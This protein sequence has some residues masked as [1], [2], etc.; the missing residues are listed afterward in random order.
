MQSCPLGKI[1]RPYRR[2]VSRLVCAAFVFAPLTL[3]AQDHN[4]PDSRAISP[5][6]LVTSVSSITGTAQDPLPGEL[7]D[8]DVVRIALRRTSNPKACYDNSETYSY[9][10]PCPTGAY[11][12]DR[13]WFSTG[14]ISDPLG[15]PGYWSWDSSTVYWLN[16]AAYDLQ[17]IAGDKAGNMRPYPGANSPD[18]TFDFV[19]P[20][21]DTEITIPAIENGS[22]NGGSVLSLAG[23][24]YNV[25]IQRGVQVR[26][27]RLA[28]PVAW[29]NEDSKTWVQT[30]TFTYVNVENGA[31]FWY[32]TGAEA[33]TVDGAS[34]TFTATGFNTANEAETPPTSRTIIV[35]NSAIMA[36]VT[37]LHSPAIE[38][39]NYRNAQLNALIGSGY[40]L[41][42]VDSIQVRIKRLKEPAAW[43]DQGTKTWVTEDV[44]SYTNVYGGAGSWAISID[45]AEAFTVDNASY[46]FSSVGFNG[47]NEPQAI[48]VTRTVIVDNTRPLGAVLSPNTP[49][50]N[51]MPVISGTAVDPGRGE[52]PGDSLNR[53]FVMIKEANLSRYWNGVAFAGFTQSSEFPAASTLNWS[54]ATAVNPALLDGQGYTIFVRPEDKA[55]N[56]EYDERYMPSYSVI[57]DTSSPVS[58]VILPVSLASINGTASDPAGV[59]APNLR[60]DIARVELQIYDATNGKWWHDGAG[61]FT[62]ES[63]SFNIVAGTAVWNYTNPSLAA[64]VQPGVSYTIRSRVV[65]RAGNMQFAD[66][67]SSVAYTGDITISSVAYTDITPPGTFILQPADNARLNFL[68]FVSGTAGGDISIASVTVSIRNLSNGFYWNGSAW[69][70]SR[71]WLNAS[72]TGSSWSFSAVPVFENGSLYEVAAKAK[73][74]SGNWSV[75][76]ATSTFEYSNSVPAAVADLEAVPG[77]TGGI[78]LSWTVPAADSEGGI[79]SS[80][81]F[82]VQYST[83]VGV[84]WYA[85]AAQINISI[86]DMIPGSRQYYP[87]AGLGGNTK[88]YFRLWSKKDSDYSAISNEAAVLTGIE[89]PSS[90]YF[91][92]IATTSIVASAY[93]SAPAFM[94]LHLGQSGT[95]VAIDIDAW[96]WAGWHGEA[97]TNK[98]PMPTARSA[99]AAAAANGRL[100]AQGGSESPIKSEEYDPGLD[101]WSTRT[102]LPAGRS[103]FGSAAVGGR[104]IVLGG[105]TDR[106]LNQQYDP[107]ADIWSNIPA[108]A[109]YPA[110][111]A[112]AVDEKVYSLGGAGRMCIWAVWSG[113]SCTTQYTYDN[114]EYDTSVMGWAQRQHMPTSRGNL[115]VAASSGKIYA[116]G[117]VNG[118]GSGHVVNSNEAY[119]PGSNSWSVLR[120]MSEPRHKLAAAALGGKIYAIGGDNSV[121]RVNTNEEYDPVSDIWTLRQPMPTARSGLAAAAIGG[122]IYV[123]GGADTVALNTNEE[124]D[125]GVAA[126]FDSLLP[127][128]RY[129]FKAKARDQ[130]G[131]ETAE[132]GL[133][134]ACTLAT[135]AKPPNGEPVFLFITSTSVRVNWSSGTTSGGFNGPGAIYSLEVSSSPA[136]SVPPLQYSTGS[137]SLDVDG[138]VSGRAYYF[139]VRAANA[140]GLWTDFLGLGSVT[141]LDA[142]PPISAVAFPRAGSF[143]TS[144]SCISGTSSDSGSG[145]SGVEILINYENTG[146]YFDGVGYNSS[147]VVW[148][149]VPPSNIYQSSWT[150]CSALLG[151]GGDSVRW[152]RVVSRATDLAGNVGTPSRLL[153][154]FALDLAPPQSEMDSPENLSVNSDDLELAGRA[155]DDGSGVF[156]YGSNYPEGIAKLELMIFR[157]IAPYMVVGGTMAF[158]PGSGWDD[159]GYFW[160]GS[161][162]TPSAGGEVWAPS[163]GLPSTF[164]DW[165]YTGLVCDNDAERLAHACWERDSIYAA[166]VRA[167]DDVG[168]VETAIA[169]GPRFHIGTP[170]RSFYITVSTDPI[171]AGSDIDMTVTALDGLFGNG[172]TVDYLGTINFYV[173]GV[174]GSPEVMDN[175]AVADNI[176]GLPQQYT[177]VPG[178]HGSKTFRMRLRKAGIRILRVEDSPYYGRFGNRVVR[179]NPA[180]PGYYKVSPGSDTNASTGF[181]LDP[182]KQEITAQFTDAFGNS[183]SSAGMPA[184]LELGEVHGSTGAIQYQNEDRRFWTDIGASTIMYTDSLGRIGVSTPIAYRV[185]RQPGDWARVWIGTVPVNRETYSAYDAAGQNLSGRLISDKLRSA[186]LTPCRNCAVYEDL[187][188]SGAASNE[189]FLEGQG[190]V[191]F[192]VFRDTQPV[193]YD[194]TT[195]RYGEWDMSG[196]F[197]NGSTWTPVSAGPVWLQAEMDALGNW[198]YSDLTCDTKTEHKTGT[199][200][201]R[202]EIYTAWSRAADAAGNVESVAE[203]Q[204]FYIL[205]KTQSFRITSA[206]HA[207]VGDIISLRVTA[208]IEPGGEGYNDPNYAGAFKFYL[209]GVQVGPDTINNYDISVDE[210]GLPKNYSFHYSDYG[211][212]SLE[213]R[214]RNPGENR[215]LMVQDAADPDI[216]GSATITVEVGYPSV[217]ILTP[218]GAPYLASLPQIFGTVSDNKAVAS[219]EV[220]L[221][222]QAD[223]LHWGGIEWAESQAWLGATLFKSS[224]TYTSI[225][226]LADGVQYLVAARARDASG[227]WSLA[228]STSIFQYDADPP[229]SAVNEP[230]DGAAMGYFSG[231]SGT[232]LDTG[233]GVGQ[234][235]VKIGRASDNAYWD[236][237]GS[238]WTEVETWALAT[239]SSTWTCAGPPEASLMSGATYFAVSRAVDAVGN[240]QA[241]GG[242]SSTFIYRMPP[243]SGAI[244][245]IAG[246]LLGP[247]SVHWSWAAGSMNAVDGYGIFTATGGYLATVALNA[248]GGA[249]YIQTGLAPDSPVSVQVGGYNDGGFGPLAKSASYYTLASAPGEVTVSAVHISSV[250]LAWSLNGNPPGIFAK[251][252]RT[253]I[254][255]FFST[256]G[257]SYTYTGLSSCTSYYFRVWNVNNSDIPTEAVDVGPAFTGSNAPPPPGGLSAQPLEGNRISLGWTLAPS[258]DISGYNLYFD[259]GS[260][261]LDYASP[262]AAL[263]AGQAGYTTGVLFSSAA[264]TFGL[265]SVNGCGLEEKNTG[266]TV[267][268]ASVHTL[269]RAQAV[270]KVPQTGMRVGGNSVTVMAELLTGP[271]ADAREVRFQYKESAFDIWLDI[272]ARDPDRHPNPDAAAPY[273][274]HW[275]V[276]GLAAGDYG[277]RAVAT[278]LSEVPDLA[279]AAITISIGAAEN[280][281][282][283]NSSGGNVTK[284][285]VVRNL[286]LNMLQTAAS[287]TGQLARLEIPPGA[288]Q[289]STATVEVTNN[290][291]LI[292]P[293][294]GDAEA[295]GAVVEVVLSNQSALTGGLKAA[296]SLTFPDADN[297][298]IVDGTT[299]H[300]E[301]LEMY[302]AH[303]SAGPW[304]R[305]IS[306]VVDLAGKKVTGYT[307]HF[308]FFALFVP[309]AVN[310]NSA[311]AYPL[312]WRPG[313]GGRF[314]SVPGTYGITFDN[315]TD[316][317]EIRI[318]TVTGQLVRE[319]KLT[320]SDLGVKVWDGKNSDGRKAASGI[321]LAR[322]KSGSSVKTLKI[323]VER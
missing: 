179:V 28:E 243:P 72:V 160:N 202:G 2:V 165:T 214:F 186:I 29:W 323:A 80:Y 167:T 310:I 258:E 96:T 88:Y 101:A 271:E 68:A 187:V 194:T 306:S 195:I 250:S 47:T 9:W 285:Q 207:Y 70:V 53:V 157:D 232:A 266:I 247:T 279:P 208:V 63:S 147:S 210:Q 227:N 286:S 308:S 251:V 231:I 182:G 90:I 131:R 159:S 217:R 149:P 289:A 15:Q 191:E 114:Q 139:R 17:A 303:S 314:D 253:D 13:I 64:A 220:S 197:W 56:S 32:I 138:L 150:Y 140:E 39:G 50:I 97:W 222:R 239:G 1:Y 103:S 75:G 44:Y 172:N 156:L 69:A 141:T 225:P 3:C 315:L 122:R 178:D 67:I 213:L 284:V 223:G 95:N 130:A 73:D 112:V 104:I 288:L 82:T 105:A 270:I 163:G 26:L 252:R 22:Y 36:A 98:A 118:F 7:R 31:W 76:Y 134:S 183:I 132:S 79:L 248:E 66:N 143:L 296:V 86:T 235:R 158:G 111:A 100:Y 20:S 155:R 249:S 162:W 166:W 290:P 267:R 313:S 234:V 148:L 126:K 61:A 277:L 127:N 117:G 113:R 14:T 262:L 83:Y 87:L 246:E 199:C 92:E 185:S 219:V 124:Y 245:G 85:Q 312:P 211:T 299:L 259:N 215:M 18:I 51:S 236:G 205:N 48:P 218:G 263:A 23:E 242:A 188:L 305:D 77:S 40:N 224:W 320:S 74:A 274:I 107:V 175:D 24:A 34:Y 287:D 154:Y 302:S 35:E 177:F 241:S 58:R 121:S 275:D 170:A 300:A 153:Y 276:T 6:G 301:R 209:D 133:F 238:R 297:D 46:T 189:V 71:A 54:T 108:I 30:D 298:G 55:G 292:P 216:T 62:A 193:L 110:A 291:P 12:D 212:K 84:A 128:T 184:Y 278:D 145:V 280:D 81:T 137:T 229:V 89:A 268:S 129:T 43:W 135:V 10:V 19:A 16:G 42:S 206:T 94:N 119:N 200:W 230:A 272:P 304:E 318:Y 203:G 49:Y 269:P 233:A 152:Y 257:V 109:I 198:Q 294:P 273:F 33:F 11:P 180:S 21:A 164:G 38:L 142:T 264:Y 4:P 176:H 37:S 237:A 228:Y 120:G 201:A 173:D 91:D 307:T 295:A 8:S 115:A 93:A 151:A 254:E 59:Y 57:Y 256:D 102:S 293:A 192:L 261:I 281:I 123:V 136:F 322:I 27:K 146:M 171:L 169:Q 65:D 144:I 168:N 319:F 5:V 181:P 283:E 190:K 125:P 60:S 316:K 240:V 204:K 244:S 255:P 25:R 226:E 116:V 309:Q 321:Y 221:R 41:R 45:A 52:L 106:N 311:M 282:N 174:P 161:S 99:F 196:Y 317:A 78:L 260:G 265:R